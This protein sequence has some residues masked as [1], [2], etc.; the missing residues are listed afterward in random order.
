MANLRILFISLYNWRY[1]E[2]I[3]VRLLLSTRHLK[4]LRISRFNLCIQ[5][6][7]GKDMKH[8]LLRNTRLSTCT[9]LMK[10]T[11]SRWKEGK[12]PVTGSGLR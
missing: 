10:A 3:Q 8:F 7:I 1:D 4:Y 2:Q 9:K 11:S 6:L 5:I 12:G